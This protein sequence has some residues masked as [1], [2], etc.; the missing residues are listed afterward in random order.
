MGRV[1]AMLHL[2]LGAPVE[3]DGNLMRKIIFALA[4]IL[5]ASNVIACSN[6][7]PEKF[8]SFIAAFRADRKFEIRRT[9]FPYLIRNHTEERSWN[10]SVT[11]EENPRT[12]SLDTN[13]K[14][15]RFEFARP[16]LESNRARLRMFFPNTGYSQ[17][18]NFIR[19]KG[20]W[21]FNALDVLDF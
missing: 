4:S 16:E 3:P 17:T 9:I 12:T 14:T 6:S 10:V 7:D 21:Y 15:A 2:H 1:S 11:P 8:D 19:T 5:I 18:F 13:A 20:C